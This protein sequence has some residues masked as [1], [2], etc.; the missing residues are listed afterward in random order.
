MPG[1]LKDTV[2][3]FHGSYELMSASPGSKHQRC[4]HLLQQI[5][6]LLEVFSLKIPCKEVTSCRNCV[7]FLIEAHACEH[8][9][10]NIPREGYIGGLALETPL[11]GIGFFL[12]LGSGE[13]E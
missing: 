13:D 1:F 8:S 5:I 2:P 7:R 11:G 9:I 12:F 4:T 3:F 6:L 10:E